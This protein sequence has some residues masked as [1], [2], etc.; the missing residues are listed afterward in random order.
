MSPTAQSRRAESSAIC[1]L[2]GESGYLP[3]IGSDDRRGWCR[4]IRRE[5]PE[6]ALRDQNIDLPQLRDDLFRVCIA[7]SRLQSSLMS[8]TLPQV[9]PL[10]GTPNTAHRRRTMK[11]VVFLGARKL[12]LREFPDPTPGSR[13]V[14]LDCSERGPLRH[15]VVHRACP[16]GDC[17]SPS[18]SAAAC[19][20]TR[21]RPG[22]RQASGEVPS[23]RYSLRTLL[24]RCGHTNHH[25]SPPNGGRDVARKILSSIAS[26]SPVQYSVVSYFK[27][28]QSFQGPP[29]WVSHSTSRSR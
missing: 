10:Q 18:A 24:F 23:G 29:I 6:R 27:R 5:A 12:E 16:T 3:T 7:S 14:I 13:D 25:R 26:G 11:G 2:S 4:S 19:R 17:T 1:P 20:G 8:K 28:T 9:G 15:L 22:R 21:H